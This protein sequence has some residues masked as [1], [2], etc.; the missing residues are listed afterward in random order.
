MPDIRLQHK[1]GRYFYAICNAG[2][3]GP[4]YNRGREDILLMHAEDY[5]IRLLRKRELYYMGS[6]KFE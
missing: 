2:I 3:N 1:R 4:V 6:P 5:F